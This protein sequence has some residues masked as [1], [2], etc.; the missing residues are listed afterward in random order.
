MRCQA[1]R[2]ELELFVLGDVSDSRVRE[3]EAHLRACPECSAAEQDY[4]LLL[5]RL[6]GDGAAAP[7]PEFAVA[8]GASVGRAIGAE[9]RRRRLRRV[10]VVAAAAAL[11]AAV[12]GGLALRGRAPADPKTAGVFSAPE[13]WRYGQVQAVPASA[14]D[15]VVVHDHSMYVLRAD[16]RGPRVV[17]VDA[18]TGAARWE[19]AG[20]S[21]GYLAA[22]AERVYCLASPGRGALALVALDAA[23]GRARWHYEQPWPHPLRE[24]SRPVPLAGGRVCWSAN[25]SLHVL[26]A[27]TGEPLWTRSVAA[28]RL[29]SCAVASGDDLYVVSATTLHC[30]AGATGGE[31]WQQRLDDSAGRGR[32]LLAL[33]GGRAYIARPRPGSGSD[34]FCLDLAARSLLWRRA[35]PAAR[36]LLAADG[37]VCLRGGPVAGLDA[38]TGKVLWTRRA[39]GCGPLTWFGGQIHFVD[40]TEQGRLVAVEPRT[41]RAAWELPGFRSCDAFARVGDL[42]YVKT[43]DGVVH[44]LAMARA[45]F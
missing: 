29:L 15:G 7:R 36:F 11:L 12:A 2:E 10:A 5:A 42:G 43:R 45:R 38:A 35:A 30:L 6:R 31:R 3:I 37:V 8:L 24:P 33:D 39:E 19:A 9:R 23:T 14:A 28:G 40:S 32:P 13:R 18:A 26:D 17:A 25:G 21:V 27:G 1:V 20:E 41:G 4:R 22:D 16:A 44:A 34:V